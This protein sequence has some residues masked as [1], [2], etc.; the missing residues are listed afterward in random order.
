MADVSARQ[1]IAEAAP[2]FVAQL[3][4]EKAARF[5]A[6]SMLIP[7][8]IQIRDAIAAIPYGATK[9]VLE[10]RQELALANDAGVTCPF[11]MS[12]GWRLVAHAAEE[13]RTEGIADVTPWWRVTRDKKPDRKMPGGIENHRA[14]L[15]TE[16]TAI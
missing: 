4:G 14:L 15:A 11:M 5:K 16:G 12:V 2:G 3:E 7:S 6:D 10:V 9:T 1:K 13:D 8:P